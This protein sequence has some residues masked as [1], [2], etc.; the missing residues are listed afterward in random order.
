MPIR[1]RT[2]KVVGDRQAVDQAG[3]LL[4]DFQHGDTADPQLGLQEKRA[5][6][7]GVVRRNGVQD[8]QIDL[9]HRQ[10]GILDCRAACRDG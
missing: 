1:S 3:T 5:A 6:R 2:D 4:S 9:V 7:I 8:D 10:A